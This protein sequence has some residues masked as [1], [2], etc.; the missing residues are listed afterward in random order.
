MRPLFS[1]LS[2]RGF[3][4]GADGRTMRFPRMQRVAL[5][6]ARRKATKRALH[7][8][9]VFMRVSRIW[10]Y[11]A[12]RSGVL[13]R[14]VHSS[15]CSSI[16]RIVRKI[17]FALGHTLILEETIKSY[18]PINSHYPRDSNG[19]KYEVEWKTWRWLFTRELYNSQGKCRCAEPTNDAAFHAIEC[20]ALINAANNSR[21]EIVDPIFLLQP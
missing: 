17:T 14:F 16:M 21:V 19:Y 2:S 8:N 9:N 6:N 11:L 15:I 3:S 18:L 1:P 12:I 10:R 7:A 5:M 20:R 4:S 13:A